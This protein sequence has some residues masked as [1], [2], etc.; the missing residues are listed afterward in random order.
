MGSNEN[1]SSLERTSAPSFSVVGGGV[2]AR[3]TALATTPLK[4]KQIYF[5][6]GRVVSQL[7][8][9]GKGKVCLFIYLIIQ[10]IL[11]RI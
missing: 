2:V 7:C 10:K 5:K 9:L 3:A 11:L 8:P 1:T 4:I 6:A